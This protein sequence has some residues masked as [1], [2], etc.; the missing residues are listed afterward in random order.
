MPQ[1]LLTVTERG[2]GGGLLLLRSQQD[3]L[4]VRMAKIRRK[5]N[6]DYVDRAN[7]R[8]GHLVSDELFQFLANTFRDALSAMRIQTSG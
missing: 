6:L 1:E 4:N 8:V 5:M 7:A 3:Q 2:Q